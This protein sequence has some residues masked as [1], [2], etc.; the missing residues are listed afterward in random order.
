MKLALI[1]VVYG[2]LGAPF[3]GAQKLDLKF[4]GLAAKASSKVELDL[5]GTLLRLA[6]RLSKDADVSGLLA[7][8]NSVHVRNYEFSRDGAF[9][10]Q[11]IEPLRN[12]VA[13]QS[14][15]S[16]LLAA[17]EEDATTEIYLAVNGDKVTGALIMSTDAREL[18]VIYMEGNMALAQ[19]KRLVNE[20]ARNELG[21]LLANR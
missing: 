11:D 17:K 1:A 20:D 19:M 15:W 5:G 8:V 7:G 2:L 9:S 14:R 13:A 10:Q 21:D 6:A 12:Q 18:H 4:D 16:K 3:A